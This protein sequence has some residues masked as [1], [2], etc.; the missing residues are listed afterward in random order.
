M[1]YKFY[2]DIIAGGRGIHGADAYDVLT[3]VITAVYA[4]DVATIAVAEGI[5]V[6]I[7]VIAIGR[8]YYLYAF[9]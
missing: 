5:G 6:L 2:E 3:W 9:R 1:G 7:G 4:A 8:C